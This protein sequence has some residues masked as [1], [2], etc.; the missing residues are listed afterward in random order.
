M[1]KRPFEKDKKLLK[2]LDLIHLKVYGPLN[3]KINREMMY[4]MKF[5][6]DYSQFNHFQ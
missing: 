5:I 4:L 2:L 3:I 1:T 6:V